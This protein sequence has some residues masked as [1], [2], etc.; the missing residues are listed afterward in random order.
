MFLSGVAG[1]L[2]IL[3]TLAWAGLAHAESIPPQAQRYR[4]VLIRAARMEWGLN[5]PTATLAAQVHQESRWR[6]NARS[7]VGAAGLTQFM[8]ATAKWLGDLRPDMGAADPWNPGWAL[9]AL[10]AYDHWLWDRARAAT[11]SDRMAKALSGYNGGESWVQRDET[12]AA[13]QGLDPLRWWGNVEVVNAG[14]SASAWDQNRG[15]P[16]RIIR[17]LEPL[18]RA[19]GWGLGCAELEAR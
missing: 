8:P 11:P 7:P 1:L 17:V 2:L 4:S 10:A 15:Y 14:R 16:E 5:A 13:R 12:L 3:F 18:Y 19:A 9:R 6:E